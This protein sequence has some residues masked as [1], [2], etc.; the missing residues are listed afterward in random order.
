MYWKNQSVNKYYFHTFNPHDM[1]QWEPPKNVRLLPNR[2]GYLFFG[3]KFVQYTRQLPNN[4]LPNAKINLIFWLVIYRFHYLYH[5]FLPN[6]QINLIFWLVIYV[7]HY[8][9]IYIP[10]DQIYGHI[11]GH[12]YP[13]YIDHFWYLALIYI[14]TGEKWPK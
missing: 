13:Y 10:P 9:S 2:A 1:T 8:L 3:L 6:V 4:F 12:N 7:F 11:Y 5:N 14:M